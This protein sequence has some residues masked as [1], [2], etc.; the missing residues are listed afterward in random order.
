MLAAALMLVWVGVFGCVCVGSPD[1]NGVDGILGFGIPKTGRC[2]SARAP[3][4]V[5]LVRDTRASRSKTRDSVSFHDPAR[6]EA[7]VVRCAAGRERRGVRGWMRPS[8]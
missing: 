5:Q 6:T 7:S 8:V 4:L 2:S 3:A 1:F